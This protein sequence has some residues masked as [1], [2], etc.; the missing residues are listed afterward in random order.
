VNTSPSVLLQT[1]ELN[2]IKSKAV[3]IGPSRRDLEQ[4]GGKGG[5]GL[6]TPE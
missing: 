5:L 3:R 4:L 1:L 2:Q 6:R